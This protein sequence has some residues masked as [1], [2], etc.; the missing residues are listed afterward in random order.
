MLAVVMTKARSFMRAPQLSQCSTSILK[1]RIKSSRQGRYP[2]RWVGGLVFGVQVEQSR[3]VASDSVGGV[4]GGTTRAR[5]LLA[6]ANTPAYLT[7]WKRG[8]GTVVARRTKRDNG[9]RSSA[10]VPSLNG[11]LSSRR[12][13]SSL[14]SR[15]FCCAIGGRRMYLQSASRPTGSSALA[16]V[17]A[18]SE[19]P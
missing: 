2:E 1:L 12:T 16:V 6:A 11:R 3:W 13:R 18:C 8:G 5:H 15:M 17:A 10:K 14:T 7:E 19:K 9:S 4:G